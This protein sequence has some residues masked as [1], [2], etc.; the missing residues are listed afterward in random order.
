M[1][2]Y[3]CSPASPAPPLHM[4][5]MNTTGLCASRKEKVR[6]MAMGGVHRV[7][8]CWKWAARHDNLRAALHEQQGT[9]QNRVGQGKGKTAIMKN[10]PLHQCLAVSS[11]LHF[12]SCA[13]A[14]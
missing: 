8:V 9:L 11:A 14:Q 4:A 13:C 1:L 3:L 7:G 2:T 6:G 5:D 12:R 10:P